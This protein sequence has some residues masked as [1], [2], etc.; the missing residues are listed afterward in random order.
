MSRHKTRVGLIEDR[1]QL[2]RALRGCES[3]KLNNLVEGE[4]QVLAA[5]IRQRIAE[6]DAKLVQYA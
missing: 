4:R 6:V 3:G 1:D 2:S 5:R